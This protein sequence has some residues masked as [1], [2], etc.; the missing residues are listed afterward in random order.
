[1]TRWTLL[2]LSVALAACGADAPPADAPDFDTA[3]APA[4][5]VVAAGDLATRLPS[6][7]A[8]RPRVAVV[9]SVDAALG[10]E[11]T[12]AVARYGEGPEVT[13]SVADLGS[14]EMAEMMGYGWGL[15]GPAPAEV[16]GHPAQTGGGVAGRPYT[17][18]V[19]VAGRF[20]VEARSDDAALAEAAVRAVDLDGLVG[21][22]R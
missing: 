14:A 3:E 5:Q 12:R 18:R 9:D 19:L 6:E 20:F 15:G 10:A 22:G 2:A 16:G 21:A 4:A 8:G 7:V 17:H 11:V 13:V 1:M